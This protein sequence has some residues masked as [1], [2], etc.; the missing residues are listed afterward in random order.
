MRQDKEL[1]FA[2]YESVHQSFEEFYKAGMYG[3]MPLKYLAQVNSHIVN[4]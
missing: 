1:F 3:Q 4:V 2:L